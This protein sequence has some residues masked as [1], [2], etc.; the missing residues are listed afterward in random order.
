MQRRLNNIVR[1][2]Q[3]IME[4]TL[5]RF[6]KV[7]GKIQTVLYESLPPAVI[8]TTDLARIGDLPVS[9]IESYEGLSS[10][11]LASTWLLEGP[12]NFAPAADL[13]SA[14][15]QLAQRPA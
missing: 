10:N 2:R 15:L 13:K 11:E 8:H 5:P 1:K 3:A 7:Y 6:V 9:A 14:P 4:Y 12:V